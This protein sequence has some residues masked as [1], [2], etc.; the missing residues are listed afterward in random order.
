MSGIFSE[1]SMKH[2]L[3]PYIPDGERL[4][5]GI[6]AVAKG[7]KVTGIYKKCIYTENALIPNE[8]G[9]TVIL[10]KEKHAAYDIYLGITQHTL[11]VNGC[12]P[13]RYYYQ[14]EDHTATEE[15]EAQTV[16]SE[17]LLEDIGKCFAFA[18]ILNCVIKKGLLGSIKCLITMKNGDYFNLMLP[19][20]GGLTRG[21]PHHTEYRN[22]ILEQLGRYSK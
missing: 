22:A 3:E 11:L 14:F 8:N 4:L 6:H 1:I 7:S 12:E 18:D 13:C 16:T 21:M 19:K 17:I 10:S 5:A 20:L 9:A 2:S 15:T